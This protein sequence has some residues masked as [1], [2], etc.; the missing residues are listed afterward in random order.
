MFEI[1]LDFTE[2]AK[3]GTLQIQLGLAFSL[4]EPYGFAHLR[5]TN[6]N[7]PNWSVDKEY[8]GFGPEQLTRNFLPSDAA[9]RILSTRASAIRFFIGPWSQVF[10]IKN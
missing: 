4:V 3:P 8:L 2:P 5:Y 1:E 6:D 9:R 10:D 7:L